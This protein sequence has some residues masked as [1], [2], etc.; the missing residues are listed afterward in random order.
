[1]SGLHSCGMLWPVNNRNRSG[2]WVGCRTLGCL[3]NGSA[4]VRSAHG[5]LTRPKAWPPQFTPSSLG[6]YFC[7]LAGTLGHIY[8]F[9]VSSRNE[10]RVQELWGGGSDDAKA[11]LS[12]LLGKT[13]PLS[14]ALWRPPFILPWVE[15]GHMRFLWPTP[16]REDGFQLQ[17]HQLGISRCFLIKGFHSL[18]K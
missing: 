9:C 12:L 5:S 13:Q 6:R 15:P 3:L 16:G 10:E 4:E 7:P 8:F 17:Y 18:N 11:L 1:M 14:E 2:R